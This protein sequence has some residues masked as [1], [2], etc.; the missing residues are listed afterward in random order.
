VKT[1][2]I[3]QYSCVETNGTPS[4]L[5]VEDNEI[6][7]LVAVAMLE[8]QGYAV[9]VVG[10]GRAALDA[11]ASKPYDAVLMD[12]QMPVMDGY[13]AAAELRRRE[14][15]G[16]LPII[17]LT[18]HTRPGERERC[19]AA[20]MDDF[21]AKPVRADALAAALER[22]IAP[23]ALDTTRLRDA[24]GSDELV[25]RIVK[26]FLAQAVTHVK[27]IGRAIAAEDADAVAR[28]AHALKGSAATVGATA[29]ARAA[30]E[31]ERGDLGA[32]GRL[33]DALERTQAQAR[34]GSDSLTA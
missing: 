13:A 27:T 9:D 31:L 18:A 26:L 7:Q 30:A 15:E 22:H 25:T 32:A 23:P 1:V 16:H 10:D 33:I 3:A 5:L 2:R 28:T 24:V 6:N 12:C 11:V 14:R 4:V 21:V 34:P 8:K 29:V 20:G 17:A 19:L